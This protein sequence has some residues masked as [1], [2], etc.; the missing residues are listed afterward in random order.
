MSFFKKSFASIIKV[1][2]CIPATIQGIHTLNYCEKKYYKSK[3]KNNSYTFLPFIFC[4][5]SITVISGIVWPIS[6]PTLLHYDE[7]LKKAIYKN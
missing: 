7:D 6:I 3:Y 4:T 2:Y 5:M 1:I